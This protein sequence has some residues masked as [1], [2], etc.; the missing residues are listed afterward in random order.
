MV[1]GSTLPVSAC[2]RSLM[3]VSVWATTRLD[4]PVEPFGRVDRVGQQVAGHAG[5]GH[6][7]VEP[8][9]GHAALRHVGRDR[10][11]LV[12]R[13]PVVEGPADAPFV[14]DLLG[15]RD[16]RHAAVVERDHVGHAGLLDRGHHLL[17]LRRRSSPAASRRRPSCRPRP[18]QSRCRGACT[19]GTQTST[20]SMSGRAM[21]FFQSSSIDS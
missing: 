19:L 21:S 15:Q 20:R 3:N 1:T 6:A 8:P 12:V 4:R 10:V 16:G 5:A 17:G 18:R 9:E 14:D 11:V 7:G 13:G 2:F